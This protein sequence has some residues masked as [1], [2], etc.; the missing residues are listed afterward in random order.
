LKCV[1]RQLFHILL[2][3]SIVTPGFPT[4]QAAGQ[5]PFKEKTSS[6]QADLG[7]ITTAAL[8]SITSNKAALKGGAISFTVEEW[9]DF[10]LC[11]E[12][13]YQEWFYV[14]EWNAAERGLQ[15]KRSLLKHLRGEG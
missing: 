5:T 8:A 12:S 15:L 11:L 4:L 1:W 13:A 9:H 2:R 3:R 14:D 7:N 6:L 10:A